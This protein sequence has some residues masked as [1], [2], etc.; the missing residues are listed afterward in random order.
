MQNLKLLALDKKNKM[1]CPNRLEQQ[2]NKLNL[3][4]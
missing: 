3:L 2:A 4:K 1:I